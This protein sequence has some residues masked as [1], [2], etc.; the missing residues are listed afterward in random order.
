MQSFNTSPSSLQADSC[1]ICSRYLPDYV[2]VLDKKRMPTASVLSLF[3]NVALPSSADNSGGH[4]SQGRSQVYSNIW[5][6]VTGGRR[7]TPASRDSDQAFHDTSIPT[8]SQ[9]R[10]LATSHGSKTSGRVK[11]EEE[12]AALGSQQL[13]LHTAMLGFFP[14]KEY[15]E[16][17]LSLIHI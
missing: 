9:P 3:R 7:T 1:A 8:V 5:Q 16:E 4:D 15:R 11:G 12:V 14:Q 10:A 13:P 17:P 6:F 2:G